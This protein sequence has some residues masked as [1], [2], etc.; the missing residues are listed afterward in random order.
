MKKVENNGMKMYGGDIF[1]LG[2][3]CVRIRRKNYVVLFL[4]K[5]Y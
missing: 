4:P 1:R 2:G 5:E 3:L